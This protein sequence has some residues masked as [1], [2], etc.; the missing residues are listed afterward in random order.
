MVRLDPC[1]LFGKL[2]GRGCRIVSRAAHDS[3]YDNPA[4]A[5][6]CGHGNDGS[7]VPGGYHLY[8][9][10]AAAGLWTTPSDLARALIGVQR[11]LD[12]TKGAF[13]SSATAKA[14]LEAIKPGHSMGFDIGGSSTMRWFR[15]SGDTEGFASLMV[16][17]RHGDGVVVMTNGGGGS[18]LA[19]D[20]VRSVARLYGWPDF[21][22]RT[23][24]AIAPPATAL[25][26]LPG[27]F[28]YDERNQFDIV[29]NGDVL[30]IAS[31]GEAPETLYAASPSEFFTLSPDL[32][33]VF[34]GPDS[35]HFQ[36]GSNVIPFHRR[37]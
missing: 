9:E 10:Q 36:L 31:P 37:R 35:G 26:T 1:S 22:P 28:I 8:P 13:L 11:S 29:R 16:A 7:P 5:H 12:S 21:Q 27:T 20:V 23:R 24:A 4:A 14:M 6:A 15:K 19:E 18:A 30:T 32:S 33:F 25:A 17:Y 34:D 3:G 2:V